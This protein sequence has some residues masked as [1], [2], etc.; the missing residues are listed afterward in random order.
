VK[1]RARKPGRVVTFCFVGSRRFPWPGNA[2]N[3]VTPCDFVAALTLCTSRGLTG[4]R[5][6]DRI[7]HPIPDRRQWVHLLNDPGS[8][9]GMAKAFSSQRSD[10]LWDLPS[11]PFSGYWG[12]G[13]FRSGK[14]AGT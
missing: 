4:C 3:E 12:W 6:D 13:C 10:Q 7:L 14:A 1:Q 2:S 9:S 11:P 5:L 8:M